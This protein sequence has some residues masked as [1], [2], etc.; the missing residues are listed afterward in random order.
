MLVQ[1]SGVTVITSYMV[2]IFTECGA[3]SPH[4]YS[5]IPTSWAEAASILVSAVQLIL[6]LISTIVLR[7][8]STQ[9]SPYSI[10]GPLH[11]NSCFWFVAS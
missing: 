3:R 6:A 11:E 8:E 9:Q 4:H 2:T 1:W 10:P 7:F 5:T